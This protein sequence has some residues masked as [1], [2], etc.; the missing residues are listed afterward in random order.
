LSRALRLSFTFRK[1]GKKWQKS[2]ENSKKLNYQLRMAAK[3]KPAGI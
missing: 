2:L 3:N 1:N